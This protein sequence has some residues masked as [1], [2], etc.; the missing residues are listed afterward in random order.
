MENKLEKSLEEESEFESCIACGNLTDIRKDTPIDQRP[1]P[2]I[3]GA[4]QPC[5]D[6]YIKV[7]GK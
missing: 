2:Y 3:E 7:Y 6:C 4:G 5:A 1:T